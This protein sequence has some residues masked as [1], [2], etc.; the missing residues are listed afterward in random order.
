MTDQKGLDISGVAATAM[1]DIRECNT[2]H[3]VNIKEHIQMLNS[4]QQRAFNNLNDHLNHQY[5]HEHGECDCAAFKPIHMFISG[6]GGTGKSFLIETIRSQVNEIWKVN[7][8]NGETACGVAA[9]TSLAAYN[10]GGVT[11]HRLF[12]LPV[13]HQG[14]TAGYW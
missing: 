5:R 12:Q 7:V 6:V 9:P 4:D 13:E 11:V 10:I 14:K 3:E 8:N 2:V 1:D